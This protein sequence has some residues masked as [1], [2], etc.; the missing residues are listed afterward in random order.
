SSRKRERATVPD[1]DTL[2]EVF[3]NQCAQ[4]GNDVACGDMRAGVIT[5]YQARL[6]VLMLA[7][8]I[9][10]LPGEHIGILLPSS[11]AA[12]LV[13]LACQLAGKIPLLINWTVGPRHL[14]TVVELSNV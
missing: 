3:L 11:V 5:F 1:G 9:R 12:Y 14:E 8:Y 7:E 2:H 10:N 13:V 4:R 6:R